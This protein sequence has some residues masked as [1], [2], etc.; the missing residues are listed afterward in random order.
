MNLTQQK[1][2]ATVLAT[3]AGLKLANRQ[4]SALLVR[5]AAD[6]TAVAAIYAN[7][8][9]INNPLTRVEIELVRAHL[10]SC[11]V[12]ESAFGISMDGKSWALIVQ[13]ENPKLRTSAARE[14]R[15]EMLRAFLDDTVWAAWRTANGTA[16]P[17]A[18]WP[19]Y[20]DG[21]ASRKS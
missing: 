19:I 3:Y 14:F 10:R 18:G 20:P 11:G 21:P 5:S 9:Y 2:F 12:R 16:V 7:D 8:N 4:R 1:A 15:T 17:E 6:G 13:T